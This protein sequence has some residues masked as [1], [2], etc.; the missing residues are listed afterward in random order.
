M[1]GYRAAMGVPDDVGTRRCPAC[2][3]VVP[4]APFCGE[5][6]A[7]PDRPVSPLTTLLRPAVYATAHRETVWLPRIS[8]TLL[9]RFPGEIRKP[10]RVGLIL[11]AIGILGFAM[12]RINGPLGV[13]STI[14]WPL[15]FLIYVWQSDV[16]R[17]VPFRILAVATALG[18]TFGVGWW[19]AAGRILATAYGVT[20]ASSLMLTRVLNTG[21]LITIGGAA[22]MLV[23]ALLCRLFPMPVRESLDGFVIGAFG[24]L[25]YSTAAATTIVAPQFAEGLIEEYSAGR[26][27]QDSS[28]YG[29]IT[30]IITTAAGGLVGM[31]LWFCPDRRPGRHP[32]RAR[33]AL[34][35]CTLLAIVLYV[36]V[37]TVDALALP[38]P[39]DMSIKFTLAALALIVVR[40][41]V[42]TT[43]LHEAPDPATGRPILCV[44]CEKVV[45]DLP[46]CSSCGVA[47]R[48]SSRSSRALRHE[49]PPV[50]E[51]A[52]H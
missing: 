12:S 46:F 26:M 38:R 20:T 1:T 47:A 31:S 14:G 7:D 13:T 33:A 4:A 9:P 34:T 19:L 51:L 8:S 32:G 18:V 15:L 6:G 11:V 39:L 42:Q 49:D 24:A 43:L 48:A 37:W 27:L 50:R 21:L 17:D 2:A 30:P 36:G 22:L 44:H 25:W 29:I 35:V 23:P 28:T 10:F 3:A 5:C 16:F 40:V 52:R 41:A 45:P